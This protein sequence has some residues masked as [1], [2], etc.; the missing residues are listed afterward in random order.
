M[1]WT[2]FLQEN[3]KDKLMPSNYYIKG[4]IAAK[5]CYSQYLKMSKIKIKLFDMTSIIQNL[6]DRYGLIALS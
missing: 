5:I 6:T 2:H 3:I 4:R 1:S